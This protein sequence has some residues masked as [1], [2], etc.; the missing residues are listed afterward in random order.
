MRS[1]QAKWIFCL[2]AMLLNLGGGPMAWAHLAGAGNCHEAGASAAAQVSPDCPEHHASK[3]ADDRGPTAPPATAP[4]CD[5]G[6]CVCA[7]PPSIPACA[8]ITPTPPMSIALSPEVGLD[9]TPSTFIDD[10]LRPPIY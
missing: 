3:A 8:V 7:A 6:S 5:G 9:A 2:I 1:K 4:C 10:A